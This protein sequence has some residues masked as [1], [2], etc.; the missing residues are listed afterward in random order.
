M[1]L[2]HT[3]LTVNEDTVLIMLVYNIKRSI[4]INT[5]HLIAINSKMDSQTKESYFN[6]DLF[7][8]KDSLQIFI[9]LWSK[10]AW[11]RLVETLNRCGERVMKRRFSGERPQQR[12]VW[13]IKTY[14]SVIT[15]FKY[16]INFKL[17]IKPNLA[18]TAYTSNYFSFCRF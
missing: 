7:K 11:Q 16:K 12:G 6:G 10:T 2:N 17:N 13:D 18:E 1:G 5:W 9:N 8:T 15:I 3:N 4:N 14:L